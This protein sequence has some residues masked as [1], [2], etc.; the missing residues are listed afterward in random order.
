MPQEPVTTRVRND[1]T[2]VKRHLDFCS[3][4]C[5]DCLIRPRHSS[6]SFG[7]RTEPW[8]VEIDKDVARPVRDNRSGFIFTDQLLDIVTLTDQDRGAG[9]PKVGQITPQLLIASAG[10]EAMERVLAGCPGTHRPDARAV[11]P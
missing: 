11:A 3:V 1:V 6:S 9:S 2:R 5:R 10:V 8:D 4:A 7:S